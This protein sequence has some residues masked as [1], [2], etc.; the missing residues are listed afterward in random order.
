MHSILERGPWERARQLKEKIR[1]ATLQML[2]G[3]QNF[4][5]YR[6]YADDVA[7]KFEAAAHV[8]IDIF[9]IFEALNLY[10]NR[11]Q[12]C[13]ES[14]ETCARCSMLHDKPGSGCAALCS[15]TEGVASTLS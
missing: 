6:N 15:S 3:G 9:R 5:G 10:G 4:V 11:Y 14:S 13:E 8:G 7:I 12:V 1:N 2:L